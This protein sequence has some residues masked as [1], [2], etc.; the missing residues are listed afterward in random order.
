MTDYYET[1]QELITVLELYGGQLHDPSKAALADANIGALADDME[2]N[3]Y[4]HDQH[5]DQM[6]IELSNDFTKGQNEY[7][8]SLTTAHQMLLA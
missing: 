2:R 8:T 1:F 5:F 6:Q 4:M 7:P 3:T